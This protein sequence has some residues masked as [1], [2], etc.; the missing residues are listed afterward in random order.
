MRLI[1]ADILDDDVMHLFISI[2][3]NPKQHTVV[4]ECRSSFRRMIEEQPPV[5]AVPVVHGEWII[6]SK[7]RCSICGKSALREYD[8]EDWLSYV[9]SDFCPN[10][11]ADMRKKV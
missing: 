8:R 2:T 1:D 4:N 3:G 6:G 9:P 10:C 5:E 7:P 11:G